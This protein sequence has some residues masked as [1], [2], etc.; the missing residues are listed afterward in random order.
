MMDFL[1]LGLAQRVAAVA[2]SLQS[3]AM[4]YSGGFVQFVQTARAR[5]M[6]GGTWQTLHLVPSR[7]LPTS[8]SLS[9]FTD[10]ITTHNSFCL[11]LR[12]TICSCLIARSSSFQ[13]RGA[14]P[15]QKT[16]NGRSRLVSLAVPD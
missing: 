12:N 13:P 10:D 1:G 16:I 3:L 2:M 9:P 8:S 4:L 5:M 7:P 14:F 6:L 11:L 15:P